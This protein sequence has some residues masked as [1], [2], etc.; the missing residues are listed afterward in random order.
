[1]PRTTDHMQ[2]ATLALERAQ[3]A[4]R[5]HMEQVLRSRLGVAPLAPRLGLSNT[6]GT[7]LADTKLLGFVHC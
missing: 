4:E 7:S 6:V 2:A 3:A 5:L 1:M